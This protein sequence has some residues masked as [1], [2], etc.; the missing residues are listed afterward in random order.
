MRG[1]RGSNGKEAEVGREQPTR[2]GPRLCTRVWGSG[3]ERWTL[4][5]AAAS[6][7]LPPEN[8]DKTAVPEATIVP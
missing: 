4:A 1:G 6:V 7:Q 8:R 3:E 2:A 5:N